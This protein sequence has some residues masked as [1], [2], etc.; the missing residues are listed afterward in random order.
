MKDV[1]QLFAEYKEALTGAGD[2]DPLEFLSQVSGN[3]RAVLEALID[4]Y[5]EQAPRRT[6]DA[7]A[8]R[9]SRSAPVAES[10]HRSLSGVSGLWPTLL[11]RLRA[12]ARVRRADLVAELASRLGAQS[13]REKV[14]GYY[15]EM[16]QGRLPAAGVSNTVLD[17]LGKIIGSSA[18]ALR[19]AGELPAAGAAPGSAAAPAFARTT[20]AAE[21]SADAPPAAPAAA[22]PGEWDEVDRLFRGG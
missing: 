12:Q 13:Q 6:F 4:A 19:K 17:A 1:E 9:E 11:P 22:P 16:E 7:T 18:G 15:H 3:D 14:A 8:F 21:A 20:Q 10:V 2:A 5:L